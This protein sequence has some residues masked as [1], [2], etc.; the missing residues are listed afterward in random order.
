M[1]GLL[2]FEGTAK[3]K[4]LHGVVTADNLVHCKFHL[5]SSDE[6][7]VTDISPAA[8]LQRGCPRE[9]S[10]EREKISCCA[11]MDTFS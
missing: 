9:T 10:H 11:V 3:L 2:G 7:W 6:L 8:S 1:P 4:R 5:L